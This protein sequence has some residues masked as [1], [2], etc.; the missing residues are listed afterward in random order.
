MATNVLTSSVIDLCFTTHNLVYFCCLMLNK[1]FSDSLCSLLCKSI[2]KVFGNF[3]KWM[4]RFFLLL[5]PFV[6]HVCV[7]GV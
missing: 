6:G 1:I 5:L 3:K 4:F 7:G 2:I